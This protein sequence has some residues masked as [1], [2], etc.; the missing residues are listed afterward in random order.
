[1]GLAKLRMV[2]L[3]W[4]P[5][6]GTPLSA[7]TVMDPASQEKVDFVS[8][9]A[10]P[11]VVRAAALKLDATRALPGAYPD[12]YHRLDLW[13]PVAAGRASGPAV[14]RDYF[15]IH[16]APRAFKDVAQFARMRE[17]AA[18]VKAI[19]A[20][21]ATGPNS[22]HRLPED[23]ESGSDALTP[24]SLAAALP[25]GGLAETALRDLQIARHLAALWNVS[26]W[27][28]VEEGWQKGVQTAGMG[29]ESGVWYTWP[30]RQMPGKGSDVQDQLWYARAVQSPGQLTVSREHPCPSGCVGGDS[31][32]APF[33]ITLSLAF[34]DVPVNKSSV[35]TP[36]LESWGRPACLVCVKTQKAGTTACCIYLQKMYASAKSC[37]Y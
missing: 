4:A 23:A 24:A 5:I 22:T 18:A 35:R 15:A 2:S 3:C 13:D 32:L 16:L 34:S 6:P 21:T 19:S 26:C 8:K 1:M 36:T 10:F 20:L 25:A 9:G 17:S 7:V 14:Y 33:H 30:A 12:L 28:L 27:G 31:F 37:G 11:S 29:M